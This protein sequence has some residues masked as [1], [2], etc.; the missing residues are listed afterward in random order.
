MVK[1]WATSSARYLK[2]DKRLIEDILHAE[3]L[4]IG[5][6]L[7][8]RLME[9]KKYGSANKPELAEV[10]GV[11]QEN[12]NGELTPKPQPANPEPRKDFWPFW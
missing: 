2:E 9:I 4:T 5:G 7:K 1:Q 6:E 3:G 10:R 8:K 12:D 11:H